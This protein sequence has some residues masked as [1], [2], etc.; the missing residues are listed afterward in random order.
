MLIYLVL[1]IN[2]Y[3]L[4]ME[5]QTIIHFSVDEIATSLESSTVYFILVFVPSEGPI[6]ASLL[7]TYA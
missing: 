3:L 2:F 5:A 1:Y 7:C 4:A 6:Y